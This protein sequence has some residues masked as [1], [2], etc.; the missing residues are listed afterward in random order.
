M[1]LGESIQPSKY[2]WKNAEGVIIEGLPKDI[3]SSI[4]SE[5]STFTIAGVAN[6]VGTHTFTISTTG[7][8]DLAQLIG[9]ITVIEPVVLEDVA[10]YSFD[11][12]IGTAAYNAVYGEAT[13]TNFQ[14][15]WIE[16]VK[17][18]ALSLPGT[19][20]NRRFEQP[21][22]AQFAMGTKPFTIEC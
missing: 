21:S 22:Y 13:A 16:G 5:E 10:H 11:E 18:N 15:S 20:E 17:K 1:E 19:P 14:P 3:S 12:T 7:N 6:E 4:N 9:T 8:K 2:E